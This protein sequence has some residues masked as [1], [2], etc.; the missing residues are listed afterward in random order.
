[1]YCA[2]CLWYRYVDLAGLGVLQIESVEAS[3][4]GTYR[5][6]ATNE[7][8]ERRSNDAQLTVN[9]APTRGDG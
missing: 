9:P 4:Q 3:D 8:R 7:A 6:I 5:C 1:V 2:A